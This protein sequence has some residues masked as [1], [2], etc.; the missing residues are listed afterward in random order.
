MS[1]TQWKWFGQDT[2]RWAGFRRRYR[3]ELA[4]VPD[5]L[6]RLLDDCRQA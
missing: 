1:L 6:S 2:D 3:D 4:Q 5:A